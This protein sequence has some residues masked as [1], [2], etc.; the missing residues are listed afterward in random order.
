MEFAAR[1]RRRACPR[2][3][4]PR[5]LVVGCAALAATLACPPAARAAEP[6][7]LD[8]EAVDVEPVPGLRR[9]PAARGGRRI[10][11]RLL[12]GLETD[13][14]RMESQGASPRDFRSLEDDARD[15]WRRA[16][17]AEEAVRAR[18]LVRNIQRIAQKD[19]GPSRAQL[20]APSPAEDP[21]R[22]VVAGF[23]HF[24]GADGE[25]IVEPCDDP[26][27]FVPAA[28][29]Y[30]QPVYQQPV[31]QQ[32]VYQPPVYQPMGE[33]CLPA[34]VAPAM[35]VPQA[36]MPLAAALPPTRH[37][38]SLDALGWWVRG[39]S[40]PPLVT[41]SPLGTP[42]DVA[43]V[44]GQPDTTI[45][46]G[47][48]RVNTGIRPGGR[49]Q[50]G[51]WIDRYQTWAVE[52]S[53]YT[54]A[55]QTANYYQHSVF[56]GGATTDPILARPFFDDSPG[57]GAQ[58]SIIVAFPNFVLPPP[59]IPPTMV[60]IDGSI[61]VKETSN[62][63]SAGAVLRYAPSLY[64]NTFR[65]SFSGGYRYFLLNEGL[66]ILAIST[67]PPF[68]LPIPLTN[69]R[70]EVFD[71]FSTRNTF[72]GG[73]IGIAG[74][75][76][77]RS[78]FSLLADTRLA[79]GNMHE[80]LTID[81]R[82]AAIAGP[83]TASFVGG[84]LAQPTNI[85]TFSQDKFALIPQV[86]VKLGFQVTPALRLT[87]GYNFTYVSSVLRPGNQIDTTVN[88]TQF[89]GMPLVGPARPAAMMD[90]TSIWLQGVTAGLDLRF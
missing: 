7:L 18:R 17:N 74:E 65:V 61:Q 8:Q 48:Q 63:Q 27:Q 5:W 49:V 69:P 75:L 40:L 67:P 53:Y 47:N 9:A 43:G 64:T 24:A 16:S 20:K 86:D 84:L 76:S 34:A 68:V 87:V 83:Y 22:E 15:A 73:E 66:T 19:R 29:V 80:T 12:D 85:G 52:G 70:V 4:G 1:D 33:P 77:G 2:L 37:Y 72:N 82:T 56:S 41:T 90:P 60:N 39:D 44:L 42:Q 46:Y 14:E 78:R 11:S 38:V 31:Y 10:V 6:Q 62:I 21:S 88:L 32:P 71:S 55:T 81:G 23:N 3:P 58:N 45:L 57:V 28:P 36:V 79:L 51:V 89:A 59:P 26:S 13:L 50:G 35:V 30:Q 54:F 25:P